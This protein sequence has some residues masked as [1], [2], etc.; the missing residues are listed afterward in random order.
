MLALA[1]PILAL[2]VK[3]RVEGEYKRR[4]KEMAPD[5]LRAAAAK[6]APK[7]DEM[8]GDFG[9]KLDAWVV[10]AGEEL[11]REV[12]EV[13]NAT[14]E[15][16]KGGVQDEGESYKEIEEQASR[17]KRSGSRIEDL[18]AALWAPPKVVVRV[19]DDVGP[20]APAPVP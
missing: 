15:A 20:P 1:A 14:Q 6:V 11:H 13:L 18:R 12:L 2:V 10:T 3:D 9:D 17:L 7:L 19:A 4:A 8:I 16:R 5:V